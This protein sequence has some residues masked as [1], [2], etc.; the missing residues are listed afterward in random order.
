MK[1]MITG[2]LNTDKEKKIS[3]MKDKDF[4]SVT[5]YDKDGNQL[6]SE[7]KYL[8]SSLRL[9]VITEYKWNLAALSAAKKKGH[10][11]GKIKFESEH[12]TVLF[13]QN[14]ITHHIDVEHNVIRI[15]GFEYDIRVSG[16]KQLKNLTKQ[17]IDYEIATLKLHMVNDTC[18]K[19]FITVYVD[20]D[21]YNA[22]KEQKR[23]IRVQKRIKEGKTT[24]DTNAFDF[25]CKDTAVD[26]YGNKYNVQFGETKRLKR[27]QQQLARQKR[28]AEK[29]ADQSSGGKTDSKKNP[30]ISNSVRRYNTLQRL[31][32]E[33]Y[34]IS[35]RK[36][37][38]AIEL[39]NEFL[40]MNET[41]VI[42]D[43]QLTNWKKK[44]KVRKKNG[45]EVKRRGSGRIIQHGIIGRLKKR[46]KAS[47]K[48]HVIDKWVPTT[49][50]CTQCGKMH[51]NI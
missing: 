19:F 11:V 8:K 6:V 26:A 18:F 48:T 49:K 50:L 40:D 29:K 15:Q 38:A 30:K 3:N 37:A 47:P 2:I 23:Q 7:L 20:R 9:G 42:Q 12:K 39:V 51:K 4:K 44:K 35:R 25:G 34:K 45:Q 14:G 17:G 46:L 32:K 13:L 31:K 24:H 16:L 1:N 33:Y 22:L 5:H 10:K 36:N 41:V 27:L 21:E 43:E 28:A